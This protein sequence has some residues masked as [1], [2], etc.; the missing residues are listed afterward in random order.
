[1]GNLIEFPRKLEWEPVDA[2]LGRVPNTHLIAKVERTVSGN[3]Y[4][5]FAWN[6]TVLIDMG[7]SDSVEHGKEAARD[8]MEKG[9]LVVRTRP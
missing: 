9:T 1:M 6:G 2:W 3:S 4:A 7:T 5:W 8:A